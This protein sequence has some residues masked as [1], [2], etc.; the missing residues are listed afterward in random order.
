MYV[1]TWQLATIKDIYSMY[2]YQQRLTGKRQASRNYI[3]ETYK[4]G[5]AFLLEPCMSWRIIVKIVLFFLERIHT[6]HILYAILPNPNPHVRAPPDKSREDT[7]PV[8]L[9]QYVNI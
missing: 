2:E 9:W 6:I 3:G 8:F 7:S 4:G 1:H 5:K